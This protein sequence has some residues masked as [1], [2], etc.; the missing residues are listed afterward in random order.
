MMSALVQRPDVLGRIHGEKSCQQ[1]LSP[2]LPAQSQNLAI[3]GT[4][5]L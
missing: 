2:L 1:Q 5:A 3:G 4:V